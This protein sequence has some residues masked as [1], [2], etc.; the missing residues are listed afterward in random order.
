MDVTVS[1]PAA[2]EDRHAGLI[3]FGIL[4]ILFGLFC[5][6]MI[7][8]MLFGQAVAA[9]QG[10]APLDVGLIAPT[11][12]TFFTLAVAAIWLG[13][14]SIQARRWARALL[15]CLGWIGLVCGVAALVFVVPTLSTMERAMQNQARPLPPAAVV[16][17][18]VVTVMTIVVFYILLPGTLVLFYRSRHVKQTCE[19]RDPIARW[20][21]RCPLPVLAMVLLQAF[22]GAYILTMF[23]I[24]AALPFAGTLVTGWPARLIWYVFGTFSLWAAWGFYRLKP[25]AWRVYTVGI[26][27]FGTSSLV[28]LLRVDLLDYYRAIGFPEAQIERLAASPVFHGHSLVGMSS[29]CLLGV[30]A[31]LFYL[32]RFFVA[33]PPEPP[34]ITS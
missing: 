16:V 17:A 10:G 1:P 31:Y 4:E 2:Y 13:V 29:L 6:L 14:G 20:T 18:K 33:D 8:L 30:A 7:P 27:L 5:M 34:P 24:G 25:V 28:S 21:D 3:V 22:G 12:L 15:L 32:R 23:R 11:L 9:R 19:T 26:L